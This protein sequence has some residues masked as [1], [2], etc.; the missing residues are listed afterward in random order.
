VDNGQGSSHLDDSGTPDTQEITPPGSQNHFKTEKSECSQQQTLSLS[1]G[2]E[3]K[4]QQEETETLKQSSPKKEISTESSEDTQPDTPLTPPLR[5]QESIIDLTRQNSL[6][7]S[8][9]F[10][11]IINS[12]ESP[13][14]K[15]SQN[16]LDTHK[17]KKYKKRLKV[18]PSN[19]L[20]TYPPNT[21]D[22]ITITEQDL[23]RLAPDNLLNDSI[24]DF[25]LRY[26]KEN[27]MKKKYRSRYHI[28]NSFFYLSLKKRLNR[29]MDKRYKYF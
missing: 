26:Y 18:K 17:T 3:P 16:E 6:S 24:I 10:I 11:S 20:F 8:A 21:K 14:E 22:A 5:K 15:L 9:D 13:Q 7:S 12:Q 28:F 1:L 23:I 4:A 27:R 2:M 19:A 25:Y 29:K